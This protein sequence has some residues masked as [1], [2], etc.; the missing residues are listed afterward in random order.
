MLGLASVVDSEQPILFFLD[1]QFAPKM[2][3]W[4]WKRESTH[5]EVLQLQLSQGVVE[6]LL[7]ICRVVLVVPQLGG[8]EDV[9][10]LEAGNVSVGTLNALANLL[11]VAINLGQIKVAVAGLESLINTIANLARSS[12]PGAISNPRDSVAR[13]EGDGLSERHCADVS[14]VN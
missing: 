8:N 12:L 2:S 1:S 6:R 5:I 11:L 3:K 10:T 4:H 7:N 14:V 13:V 9:F